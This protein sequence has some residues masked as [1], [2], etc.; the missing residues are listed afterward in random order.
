VQHLD[1]NKI[2]S[3]GD[4]K[5]KKNEEEIEKNKGCEKLEKEIKDV[6]NDRKKPHGPH[7]AGPNSAERG[8]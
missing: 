7:S 3:F 4:D 8:V 2:K 5:R 6:A 1:D